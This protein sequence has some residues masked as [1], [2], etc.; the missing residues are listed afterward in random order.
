MLELCH[1]C[2][3]HDS[4]IVKEAAPAVLSTGAKRVLEN[5]A[6]ERQGWDGREA[7]AV[8]RDQTGGGKE[9][10]TP[11]PVLAKHVLYQLSY[12]PARG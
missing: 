11:D 4:V 6:W 12:T 1:A 10:R 3:F 5:A 8:A 9:I 7:F 2:L